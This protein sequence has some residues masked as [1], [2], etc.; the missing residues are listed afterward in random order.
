MGV[1]LL[2][3]LLKSKCYKE[4]KKIHLSELC[5]K[6]ICVDASIYLYRFKSQDALLENMY[7]MCSLFKKYNIIP[8][9]VFDGK[10]PK[11]KI[12]ELELRKEE[13]KQAK[14]EYEE[15]KENMGDELCNANKYKLERLKRSMIKITKEDVWKVLDLL[16]S[17]GIKTITAKGEADVLC[18]SLVMKKK[19]HAVLTEDMDLFA[20]GCPYVLRYFS[21]SNHTCILYDLNL[22]LSKLNLNMNDFK[23]LC[24]LSGNDYY[25]GKNNIYHNLSLYNKFKL[26]E[27]SISFMDWLLI[28]GYVNEEE[29]GKILNILNMYN[30]I[31]NELRK[32][33]Y[34]IINFG[35][36][37]R[38]CLKSILEM[39]RFI[40]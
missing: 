7:I 31:E 19:V 40:F 21:L 12:P 2:S 8:L 34:F 26:S 37:N 3:K 16:K 11:E 23:V 38:K 5:G 20:Y 29:N 27:L 39:E 30:S 17:Y 13:R 10:P 9:F 32:Y 25:G 36:I 22:I 4:S 6:K 33:S 35:K 1:K 24:V 15:I 28:E 14:L 18:A